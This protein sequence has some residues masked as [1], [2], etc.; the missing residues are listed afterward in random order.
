MS[1]Y[2]VLIGAVRTDKG[3]IKAGNFVKL[4][5]KDAKELMRIGIVEEYKKPVEKPVKEEVIEEVE[6]QEEKVEKEQVEVEPDMSWT[7]VELNEYAEKIGIEES[8]SLSNKQAV[9]DAIYEHKT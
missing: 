1:K 3:E 5:D 2:K 6:Q 9:L 7:R 4:N 8:E